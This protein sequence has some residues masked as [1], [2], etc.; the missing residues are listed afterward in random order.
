MFLFLKQKFL[1]LALIMKMHIDNKIWG[2]QEC[3]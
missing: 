3:Y 2:R 1:Y